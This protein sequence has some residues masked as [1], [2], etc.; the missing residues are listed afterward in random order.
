MIMLP[1]SAHGNYPA[2]GHYLPKTANT[3]FVSTV[4]TPVTMPTMTRMKMTATVVYVI[5]SL[6]VGQITF[7]SSALTSRTKT[8]G[9]VRSGFAGPRDLTGL[10]AC[11]PRT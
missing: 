6:R 5:S 1:R 10:L 7:L 4:S 11:G 2:L 9:L 3:A 8:A